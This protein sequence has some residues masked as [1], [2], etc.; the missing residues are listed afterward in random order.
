MTQMISRRRAVATVMGGLASGT[1]LAQSLPVRPIKDDYRE[2]HFYREDWLG[3][4]WKKPEAVIL[5]HG[6]FES[7]TEWY[8]WVPRMAQ[9][10]RLIR[11]DLPGMGHSSIPP[12]FEHSLPNLA[13]FVTQVMDKAGVES[14]HIVGA[15]ASG[16]VAMRLAADFPQRTRSLVVVSGLASSLTATPLAV[17]GDRLGSHASKEMIA[18]WNSLFERPDQTGTE[19]LKKSV[20]NFNFAKE[21]VL[22]RIAAPTLVI[23]ADRGNTVETTRAWQKQIPKSRLAVIESDGYHIAAVN[24]EECVDLTM[25]FL[26]ELKS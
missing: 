16:A 11:P 4:P 20:S 6:A 2:D 15:K 17:Q 12:G 25:R 9:Q 13:Q 24:P 5:I 23:T 26:K 22:Q 3:E 19:G 21:G 18:Y 14:A 10:Y 8:A 1:M 7:S